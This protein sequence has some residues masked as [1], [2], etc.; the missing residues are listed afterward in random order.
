MNFCP[1]ACI[2]LNWA[3]FRMKCSNMPGLKAY[4]DITPYFN[5]DSCVW[6]GEL[7]GP[8]SHGYIL[9]IPTPYR[10][11]L[12]LLHIFPTPTCVW[13]FPPCHLSEVAYTNPGLW[14]ENTVLLEV[15]WKTRSVLFTCQEEECESNCKAR[16]TSAHAV[17]KQSKVSLKQLDLCHDTPG[18]TETL[19][20]IYLQHFLTK[21]ITSWFVSLLEC[22]TAHNQNN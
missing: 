2:N 13:L 7:S 8:W 11:T 16:A 3:K 9:Y 20:N 10:D 4:N 22:Q 21:A 5:A 19:G 18:E 14:S 15:L 1:D 12:S 6:L 17:L